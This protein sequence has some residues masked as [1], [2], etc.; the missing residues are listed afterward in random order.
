MTYSVND[1]HRAPS[2]SLFLGTN[3]YV[4]DTNLN[5]GYE[6]TKG[7]DIA[8]SYTHPIPEIMGHDVG[9]VGFNYNGTFLSTF[10]TEPITD[11]GVY[12]CAGRY[13]TVCGQPLPRYRHE[14]RVTYTPPI[15]VELSA[16][17]RYFSPV[18]VE[19]EATNNSFLAGTIY[20]SDSH[21]G[22][23]SYIDLTVLYRFK[24][25][26]NFRVGCN[27]VF[28]VQPPTIAS[29]VGG[30]VA[31]YNGNTYA[32]LYDVVGRNLFAGLTADF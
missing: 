8:G 31:A 4:I 32:A 6:Q 9:R 1:I 11:G 29:G 21:I 12:N 18:N 3:G 28:N 2:G 26:Y 15:P 23:F 5:S 17:W 27:N 16:R 10:T 24:D 22:S 7:I 19:T 25:R 20:P 13:G 30:N 14:F